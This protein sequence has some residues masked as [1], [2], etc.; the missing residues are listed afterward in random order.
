[1]G[2][3]YFTMGAVADFVQ[4]IGNS[5]IDKVFDDVLG[6]ESVAEGLGSIWDLGMEVI[7]APVDVAWDV[8]EGESFSRSFGESLNRIANATQNFYSEVIDDWA[9]LD[10]RNWLGKQLKDILYDHAH[11]TIAITAMIGIVVATWYL[12]PVIGGFAGELGG[13]AV[14]MAFGAGMASTTA[15]MAV[16]YVTY[17]LVYLALSLGISLL[18]SG[19]IEGAMGQL[20]TPSSIS[21][22]VGQLSHIEKLKE[23]VRSQNF[24]DTMDGTVFEKMAGGYVYNN[25]YAGGDIYS[26]D[27]K[28]SLDASVGGE[29]SASQG[30]RLINFIDSDQ[31][32]TNIF[33]KRFDLNIVNTDVNAE[34][35]GGISP[36]K[37]AYMKKSRDFN[38][39]IDTYNAEQ[40]IY[41]S[42][43][44]EYQAIIDE[45]NAMPASK[46]TKANYD[47]TISRLNSL[48]KQMVGITDNLTLMRKDLENFWKKPWEK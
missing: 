33:E 3:G 17:G 21:T 15:L 11:D 37:A 43:V 35:R 12:G 40:N 42:K 4:D 7:S 14:S 1:M 47:A 30:T 19:M 31:A 41:N 9:G 18:M 29:F 26:Y 24:S 23:Q 32:G 34:G 20:L 38:A 6:L 2:W 25:T 5:V 45:Y 44:K 28:N 13:L 36:Q 27:Q 22:F 39:K 46:K 48:E 16:Y 8:V 10:D